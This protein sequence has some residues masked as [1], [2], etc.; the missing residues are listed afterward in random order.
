[1]F[2]RRGEIEIDR[3]ERKEIYSSFEDDY[4]KTT[5]QRLELRVVAAAKDK[6]WQ[7]GVRWLQTAIEKYK[8]VFYLSLGTGGPAEVRPLKLKPDPTR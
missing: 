3:L 6:L 2:D 5:D 4:Q 7:A 8:P 1:M